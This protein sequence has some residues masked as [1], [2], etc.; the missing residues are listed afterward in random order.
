M[1]RFSF[2]NIDKTSQYEELIKEFLQ[3]FQYEITSSEN[4]DFIYDFQGDKEEIKKQIYNDLVK[5]TGKA[6]RW[7]ILTGIRPVKL[8]GEL[9]DR[10]FSPSSYLRRNYLVEKSKAVLAEEILD[11]QRKIIGIPEKNSLSMYIGIPFCPTRCLYCSFTSNQVS[12]SEIERYLDALYREIDFASSSVTD[13][14][15]KLESVYLGG[16]TPTTL[17]AKQLDMLLHKIS[18]GFDLAKLKEFTVEAGR[19]DTID[20]DRLIVLK[21]Y[22]VDRISINPQTMKEKTLEIIGRRHSVNDI[23]KAFEIAH[24]TGFE[25]INTDLIAGLPGESF[26]D[27]VNS[28]EEIV[29]LGASNITLHTLAVKRASKLKEMDE[30]FNYK[31]EELR[32][33]MLDWAHGALRKKGYKPYYLYR[34]KHTSGNTENTG[35]CRKDKVS[36]Y[37]IR[38]MEEAQSILALGAGGISK[39]YFPEENRL[40]RVANVSNFEIYINRIDEM[41]DRK[42]KG[43]FI[44][45]EERKC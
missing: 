5:T 6:P 9:K 12:D 44:E 8:A 16:G 31:E 38:I 10:G 43:F 41:I 2:K 4:A 39:R 18:K 34:Q 29:H 26:E 25:I 19:P 14:E 40:E 27:F 32:E 15:Y 23:Y 42:Q 17:N 13:S 30:N 35:F 33:K 45:T 37:N 11:Y 22:G 21:S 28:L 1:Y 36:A 20:M 3:P 24:E 7:G